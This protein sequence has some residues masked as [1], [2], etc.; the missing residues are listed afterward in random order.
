MRSG[1]GG[2]NTHTRSWRLSWDGLLPGSVDRCGSSRKSGCLGG[3]CVVTRSVGGSCGSLGLRLLLGAAA[4][5][6]R[7]D[8]ARTR[9]RR[10]RWPSRCGPS[11]WRRQ[12]SCG[13]CRGAPD[14]P[15]RDTH[16]LA[17][18]LRRYALFSDIARGLVAP[19][20]CHDLASPPD[21]RSR[22]SRLLARPGTRMDAPGQPLISNGDQNRHSDTYSAS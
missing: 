14:G 16:N 11:C 8:C 20:W 3:R 15:T 12:R 22:R 9:L 1:P 7:R 10:S 18:L 21:R 17:D 19:H 13:A 6:G 5:N 2:P 4:A